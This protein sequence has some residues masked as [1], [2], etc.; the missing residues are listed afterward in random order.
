MELAAKRLT[1]RV[2]C[3]EG[4]YGGAMT[5]PTR[6]KPWSRWAGCD[7]FSVVAPVDDLTKWGPDGRGLANPLTSAIQRRALARIARVLEPAGTAPGA[8][9]SRA[10]LDVPD[11]KSD[12]ETR[13]RGDRR[14]M[15]AGKGP[16]GT[17]RP[18]RGRRR[19]SSR[20]GR[21]FGFLRRITI[22][23]SAASGVSREAADV[24]SPLQR[25]VRRH[26][27]GHS[28]APVEHLLSGNRQR[29]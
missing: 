29:D 17:A 12:Q 26:L 22:W 5:V 1:E 4:L 9:P 2:R 19:A 21:V 6:H 25:R 8:A 20:G 13:A 24:A 11:A 23:S 3:N 28:R 15:R 10:I 7:R 27:P 14:A 18:R 16:S